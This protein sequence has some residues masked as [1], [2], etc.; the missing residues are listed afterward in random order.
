MI[1]RQLKLV[2]RFGV[3]LQVA[4]QEKKFTL[5]QHENWAPTPQ[6]TY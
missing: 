4:G 1:F 6:G 3:P 2:G 5:V